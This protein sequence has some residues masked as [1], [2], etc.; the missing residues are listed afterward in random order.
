MLSSG[1]LPDVIAYELT[2]DLEKLGIDGGLIPLEDL[3]KEHD[4][5]YYKILGRES[6][7]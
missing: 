7:I 6:S 4:S 2:P 1:N 5:K 3:I